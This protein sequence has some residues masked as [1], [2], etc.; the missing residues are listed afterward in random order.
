MEFAGTHGA[1]FCL[2]LWARGTFTAFLR[3]EVRRP[4]PDT[5]ARVR[6]VDAVA[7]VVLVVLFVEVDFEFEVKEVFNVG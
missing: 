5:A 4:D 1:G 7:R 3:V 2:A 6:A